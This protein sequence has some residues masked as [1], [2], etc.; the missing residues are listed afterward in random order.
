MIQIIIAAI[1]SSLFLVPRKASSFV[2]SNKCTQHVRR[3]DKEP[4]LTRVL[5]N[6]GGGDP[7]TSSKQ[8]KGAA[9]V[10]D[11]SWT[12]QDLTKNND[13]HT[14]IPD[15]DYI[16][17]YQRRPE[18]WPVEFFVV[19]YRR[20]YNAHTNASEGQ[21]LARKSANGTSKYG[22]GT[23]VPVTRW[24]I[25]TLERPPSGYQWTEPHLTFD[26]SNYPEFSSVNGDDAEVKSW[27]YRKIDIC[28]DAFHGPNTH[29]EL[30]DSELEEYSKKVRAALKS[31]L[32]N[33]LSE[34]DA[35]KSWEYM[36][37]SLIQNVVDKPNSVAAIQGALRMSGLFDFHR[38]KSTDGVIGSS[39]SRHMSLAQNAP[40]PALLVASM[41][42]YTMFPQMPDP[43]PLPSTSSE[44]LQEEI[45]S[46]PYRM[47]NIGREPH[48]DKHGRIFTHISTSNVSNTI[49]G[50]YF[51]LDVTNLVGLD[52]VPALDLF[53]TKRI[54]REWASLQDL[55]VLDADGRKISMDDTKPTF[56]SGFIIKQ[57]IREGVI[58][59][60]TLVT[61]EIVATKST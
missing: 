34:M 26:A 46:R 39:K 49:H 57:L 13:G 5:R 15:D 48:K 41:R 35:T 45:Q 40:D 51:V 30:Q 42:I 21:I 10:L 28:E 47:A 33:M 54:E 25:S 44:E 20:I 2:L 53:G 61:D 24:I 17:Q 55:K 12:P 7:N 3:D 14:P 18:L 9:A 19:P 31:K 43:M 52:E 60:D 50:I 59:V 23:G 22:L 1:L 29:P 38:E 37:L 58:E 56:I 16:K 8:R 4:T 36:R 32:S 6:S 11:V 27:T